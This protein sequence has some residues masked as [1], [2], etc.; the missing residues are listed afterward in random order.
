MALSLECALLN[1]DFETKTQHSEKIEQNI[2][3][4]I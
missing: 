3:S 4:K 2:I 1:R